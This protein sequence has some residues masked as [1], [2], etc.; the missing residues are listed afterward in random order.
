VRQR[1][2]VERHLV[3]LLAPGRFGLE[4]GAIGHLDVDDMIIGVNALFHD[5]DPY[6]SLALYV[7]SSVIRADLPR[8]STA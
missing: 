4:H 7:V 5:P 3:A 6:S 8:R 1:I 2:D